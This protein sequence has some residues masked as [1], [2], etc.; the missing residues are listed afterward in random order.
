M[1][2][3]HDENVA[4]SVHVDLDPALGWGEDMYRVDFWIGIRTTEVASGISAQ[5]DATDPLA[6]QS[7]NAYSG[8]ADGSIAG[9]IQGSFLFNYAGVESGNGAR[10][11][12]FDTGVFSPGGTLRYDW[13]VHVYPTS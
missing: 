2:K 11:F 1:A 13:R 12:S 8:A 5:A 7:L 9:S 10:T 3:Y 4:G 6:F